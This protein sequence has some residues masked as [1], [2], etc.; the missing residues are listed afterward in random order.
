MAGVLATLA[1]FG[2]AELMTRRDPGKDSSHGTTANLSASANPPDIFRTDT[3]IRADIMRIFAE[4]P[5]RIYF[6]LLEQGGE[7]KVFVRAGPYPELSSASYF[8][9]LVIGFK[10]QQ[11]GNYDDILSLERRLGDGMQQGQYFSLAELESL[12][13]KPLTATVLYRDPN[14]ELE[15]FAVGGG[16]VSILSPELRVFMKVHESSLPLPPNPYL[17]E[18]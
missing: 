9:H 4:H 2:G 14:G 8:Q 17:D 10:L 15:N 1:V 6:D 18:E 13:H 16:V 11:E 5:V 7:K 12:M 3:E